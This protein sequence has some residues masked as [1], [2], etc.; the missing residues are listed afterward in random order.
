MADAQ[1]ASSSDSLNDTP[2]T[3]GAGR[4]A[5]SFVSDKFSLSPDP[6]TWGADL[7]LNNPEPDDELHTPDPRRDRTTDSGGT[8]FTQRGISNLGC[9]FLLGSTITTLFAGYPIINYLTTHEMSFLGGFNLGGINA[10]G[11]V[12]TMPGKWG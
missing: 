4:Q 11:Q 7:S 6:T 10:S 2:Y 8:L 9:L 3:F 5:P 1:P 12:P